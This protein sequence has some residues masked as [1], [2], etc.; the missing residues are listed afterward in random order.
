MKRKSDTKPKLGSTGK[1]GGLNSPIPTSVRPS[2]PQGQDPADSAPRP[3]PSTVPPREFEI[4]RRIRVTR[5]DRVRYSYGRTVNTG[6][7]DS[8]RIDVG[9]SSDVQPG[10]TF[11]EAMTRVRE[12]VLKE[13]SDGVMAIREGK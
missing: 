2:P 4:P 8:T 12:E 3:S 5:F 10:E 9:V 11:N 1:K 6:N 13:V 7:Y